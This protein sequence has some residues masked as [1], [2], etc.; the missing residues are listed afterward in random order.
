[1]VGL[2]ENM[3]GVTGKKKNNNEKKKNKNKRSSTYASRSRRRLEEHPGTHSKERP[4]E[5]RDTA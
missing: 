4:E 2:K 1:M 5:R 3:I